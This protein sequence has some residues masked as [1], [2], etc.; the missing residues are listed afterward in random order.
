MIVI[1]RQHELLAHRN[2]NHGNAT[3]DIFHVCVCAPALAER[4]AEDLLVLRGGGLERGVRPQHHVLAVFLHGMWRERRWKGRERE[5]RRVRGR[6][7]ERRRE[8]EK[9]GDG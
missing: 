5:K 4:N 6:E 7:R 8:K 3:V 2:G 9:E 1:R